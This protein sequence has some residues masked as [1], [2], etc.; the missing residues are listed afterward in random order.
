[1]RIR[2]DFSKEG[3]P[4]DPYA[5][6]L[7]TV[8]RDDKRY[9][10]RVSALSDTDTYSV[11]GKEECVATRPQR[12]RSNAEQMFLAATGFPSMHALERA[13]ERAHGGDFE[14][15]MGHPSQFV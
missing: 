9:T 10:L 13:Y 11:S 2:I 3:S 5:A 8:V 14:D 12:G 6:V 4:E 1:M 7:Y 15:P